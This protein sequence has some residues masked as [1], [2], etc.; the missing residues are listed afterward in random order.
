LVDDSATQSRHRGSEQPVS[1]TPLNSPAL[2]QE[3]QT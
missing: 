2:M 3:A 1:S